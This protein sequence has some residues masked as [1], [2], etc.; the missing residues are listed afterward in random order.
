MKTKLLKKI[1]KRFSWFVKD[2]T[3]QHPFLVY[4]NKTKLFLNGGSLMSSW[5]ARFT[6]LNVMNRFGFD[7]NYLCQKHDKAIKLRESKILLKS[8]TNK[9]TP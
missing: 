2:K 8:L 7:H 5:Y 6:I 4:D 1:R 9:T 3:L